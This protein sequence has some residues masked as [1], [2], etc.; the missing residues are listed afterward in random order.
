MQLTKV[1]TVADLMLYLT[2]LDPTAKVVNSR[3]S[4][5]PLG[6]S[7]HFRTDQDFLDTTYNTTH[8]TTYGGT[9]PPSKIDQSLFGQMLTDQGMD[10]YV[11]QDPDVDPPCVCNKPWDFG[12][13]RSCHYSKEK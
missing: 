5:D 7:V 10:G 8:A 3:T 13:D 2:Q 1:R 11:N 6:V 12:H 4:A 9:T